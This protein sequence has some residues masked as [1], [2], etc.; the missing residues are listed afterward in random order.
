MTSL[1]DQF[2][3]QKN[4]NHMYN[5]INDLIQERIGKSIKDDMQYFTYY[6]NKLR[7]IFI[8]SE[9]T[10]L[11]G[12]NKELLGHHLK[13]FIEELKD[14]KESNIQANNHILN[15]PRVEEPKKEI[16]DD[17][18]SDVMSQF[19]EYIQ[20]R[21][22]PQRN[23]PQKDIP[24]DNKKKEVSFD[25]MINDMNVSKESNIKPIIQE[26]VIQEPVIQEPIIKEEPIKETVTFTSANRIDIES[27]RF[28]YRVKCE[29][30]INKLEKLI[31]PI[32]QSIHFAIPILNLK[33]KEFGLDTNIYLK[34]TYKLN[35]YTYGIYE[36]DDSVKINSDIQKELTIEI[37]S[38]YDDSKYNNDI[39][40]CKI[41]EDIVILDDVE[42]FKIND[43]VSINSKEFVKIVEIEE[44]KLK[45]ENKP[46]V[47]DNIPEVIDNIPEVIDN[48]PEVIDNIP[49]VEEKDKIYIMNMNLQN[50][51][52]FY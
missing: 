9:E 21:D 8:E 20:Q 34:D 36:P 22:I 6:N 15:T 46:E 12:L 33:I 13:Y 2:H 28:D 44:G 19:N 24:S 39:L 10:D 11:I 51:L 3:S 29:K 37:L 7:E 49:E 17:S 40:E 48:I 16:Q 5:L 38:I 31:I 52:V 25:D 35:N 1:Y 42:D 30:K 23:I 26:L 4:I 27:N 43:I 50:T 45:L 14:S 47:I 32:E 41:E 18:N